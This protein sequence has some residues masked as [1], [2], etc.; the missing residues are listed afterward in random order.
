VLQTS[1]DARALAGGCRKWPVTK[2]FGAASIAFDGAFSRVARPKCRMLISGRYIHVGVVTLSGWDLL[3]WEGN[4]L[5]SIRSYAAAT[6]AWKLIF[7]VLWCGWGC[8][9]V[10]ERERLL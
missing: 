7:I 5:A 6:L 4:V 9:Y 10:D 8:R 2:A 3:P 1:P